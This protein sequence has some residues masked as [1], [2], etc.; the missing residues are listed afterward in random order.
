M[1]PSWGD[2]THALNGAS[3]SDAVLIKSLACVTWALWAFLVACF[4][5]E[6]RA[7]MRG[8]EARH[9]PIAGVVQPIMRELVVSAAL[10]IGSLRPSGVTTIATYP[11]VSVTSVSSPASVA[12]ATTAA[13]SEAT[14]P[15]PTCVVAP[16][17]SL[18]K[19]AEVHL[20]DGLRWREI[21]DLNR[22]KSFPDGRRFREPSLINPGWTLTLPTDA[23][24]V[25]SDVASPSTALPPVA[26]HEVPPPAGPPTEPP[27]VSTSE[28]MPPPPTSAPVRTNGR[29]PATAAAS[30]EDDPD[31]RA[32][33]L[34]AGSAL[35][36]AALIACLSR[37]RRRQLRLRAPGHMP[38]LPGPDAARAEVHLRR[39][40]VAAPFDRLDSALRVLAHSL[41]R[42]KAGACPSI[43]AVS[44]G[45]D[46]IEILLTDAV[47][48]P[49]GPFDVEANGRAWTLPASLPD[50]DLRPIANTQAGPSPALVTVGTIDERSVLIDLEAAPRTLVGG[51]PL[52]AESLLW[53]IALDLITSNRA[54]DVNVVLVGHP[55]AGFD[56]LSRARVFEHLADVMDEIER[57]A[58]ALTEFLRA[59]RRPTTFDARIDDPGDILTPIVVLI[60]DGQP[61]LDRLLKAAHTYRGLAVVVAGDADGEFDRELCVEDDTLV[62]KP[63]GLRLTPAHLPPEMLQASGELLRVAA[64]VEAGELLDLRTSSEP[65]GALTVGPHEV[66]LEFDPHGQPIVPAGH[67]MVKVLGPV[68]IE[69]GQQPIDRRRSVEL[70]TYLAM[71]PEGVDDGRLRTALWPEG[72]PTQ[73]AFNETVS[74]ARRMLGLDPQGN[75]HLRNVDKRRYRVGPFVFTDAALLEESIEGERWGDAL[76]LVRGM[77]FDATTG[78]YEWAYEEGQAHRLVVLIEEAGSRVNY[79]ANAKRVSTSALS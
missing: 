68:E 26:M 13:P 48:A 57:E 44:V 65:R 59:R 16:R 38:R 8:R 50:G 24:V 25:P 28:P 58:A 30:Q 32:V 56:A 15:P 76:R 2:L 29:P 18:W 72:A 73:A 74:K 37:L 20:G 21:W 41:G 60:A 69:G 34:L 75:H 46:A 66:L 55:P 17:D 78:G 22:D 31:H 10:L 19:L 14:P 61:D 54:D 62:L 51:D 40:A 47:D 11:A 36:A 52:D 79:P 39:A 42:R 23:R 64:D 12:T 63:V 5:V 35:V 67:V 4:A 53:T 33:P 27:S 43:S 9:I 7:W 6:T 1:T 71:H 3:I 45:P 70:V 77:P 49:T